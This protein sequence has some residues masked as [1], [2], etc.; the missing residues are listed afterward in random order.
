[1]NYLWLLNGGKLFVVPG[2]TYQHTVDNHQGEEGG[3]YQANCHKTGN[4][5]QEIEQKLRELK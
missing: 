4:F 5:H 2:L 1:M 3:H